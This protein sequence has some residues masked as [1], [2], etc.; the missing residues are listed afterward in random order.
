MEK[1]VIL[2]TNILTPYRKFFYDILF[3]MFNESG[4]AF[5]V[6]VTA[7]SEP[8]RNWTYD[9]LKSE[10]TS[11]A[12]GRVL[13]ISNSIYIHLNVGIE[14]L[15]QNE[16]PDL[17]ISAGTYL[18]PALWTVLLNRRKLGYQVFYWNESHLQEARSYSR[19]K[20]ALREFIRN[21]IFNAF[22]GFLYAG[23]MSL[24]LI[25]KYAKK[26]TKKIFVP[27]LI[28]NKKYN[29]AARVNR[30]DRQKARSARNIPEDSVVL[31]CPGRLTHV[32]GQYEFLKIFINS[33]VR[34]RFTVLLAGDGED[35]EKIRSL[36]SDHHHGVDIRLLGYLGQSQVVDVYSISDF[37]LLPSYSDPNPLCCIEALW[38]GL[39]LVV[40]SH[41]GNHP[42]TVDQGVNGY[43][44]SYSDETGIISMIERIATHDE[45]WHQDARSKSLQIAAGLYDARIATRAVVAEIRNHLDEIATNRENGLP[46]V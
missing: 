39:P 34:Q 45:R 14:R 42:E 28:D 1:K 35:E 3:Q 41:V 18:Y 46:E 13:T 20:I 29:V 44:F 12:K 9:D 37:L 25:D 7:E 31:F 16:R 5:K 24:G 6:I 22:D 38:C 32:K 36:A 40:S 19:T 23:E 21:R 26:G 4:V 11:L 30:E 15:L 43:V 33:E 27:N 8:N 2:L 10:Y 17:V